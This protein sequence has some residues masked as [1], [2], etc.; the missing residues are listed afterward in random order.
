MAR[1]QASTPLTAAGGGSDTIERRRRSTGEVLMDRTLPLRRGADG[2]LERDPVLYQYRP[3]NTLSRSPVAA[4]QQV[5]AYSIVR[6]LGAGGMGEVYLAEHRH[7]ARRAAI[8]LLRAEFSADEDLL[9]RF[10]AE[11]R[12]ASSIRHPGIIEILDC[13]VDRTTGR[14]FIVMEHLEGESL[15][16]FL[17]RRGALVGDIGTAELIVAQIAEALAAAH[18][19]GIVHRDLK[20]ANVFL[21][22][23]SEA[24]V[25]VR[26]KVLDFGIAKFAVPGST[27]VTR[28]GN[29][30]GTP[31]YMSPEQCRGGG[32]VDHRTDIYAL[33]CMAFELLCGR[34]PFVRE[35]A[36]ELIVAHMAEPPP[37]M[38]SLQPE[39][40]PELDALVG[41]M[42]AK[43]P[44]Q[45]PGSMREIAMRASQLSRMSR[46]V[47]TLAIPD[48]PPRRLTPGSHT[49]LSESASELD[50]TWTDRGRRRWL[51][52]ALPVAAVAAVAA[53]LLVPSRKPRHD[54]VAP[55]TVP[56]REE[57]RPVAPPPPV[58]E[59]VSIQVVSNPP[60]AAISVDGASRG[61][62][63]ISFIVEPGAVV[64][65]R[66]V[67]DGYEPAEQVVHAVRAQTIELALLK[68]L[69]PRR[70]RPKGDHSE[71]RKL[72][73]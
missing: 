47:P 57:L 19:G 50:T 38:L 8:K 64:R 23:P 16:D 7:L 69:K 41:R 66:A 63:P 35:A 34:P 46:S 9:A 1:I 54:T 26:V 62:A 65:L 61:A 42:L 55:A 20:P 27:N 22:A 32:N 51:L 12:A 29:I 15:E 6:K 14:P 43:D 3:I 18:A 30:L 40:P 58:P 17:T 36:G 4:G 71:Y 5:G 37:S 67:L 48:E 28:T 53:L 59:P 49:T 2:S 52:L 70:P 31:I 13:D 21:M 72:G 33:G 10:F 68:T 24:G 39:V 44:T 45:R 11:A 73:D 60:G 25:P 56:A